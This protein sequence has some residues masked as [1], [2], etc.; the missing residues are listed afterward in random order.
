MSYRIKYTAS[1]SISLKVGSVA[2]GNV[3]E[4][5]FNFI[6]TGIQQQKN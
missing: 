6:N 5:L 3:R 1:S 4:F 2:L